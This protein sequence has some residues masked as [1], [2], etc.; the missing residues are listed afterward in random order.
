MVIPLNVNATFVA[1]ARLAPLNFHWYFNGAVPVTA[2]LKVAVLPATT[3]LFV[4]GLKSD[5]LL[6][7]WSRTVTVKVWVTMLLLAPPSLTVTV[8]VP[9]PVA[10]ATGVK[11]NV[12]LMFGLV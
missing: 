12:P 4:N 7:P 9:V 5:G 10:L 3:T 6:V 2:T 11:V 1:E 8:M